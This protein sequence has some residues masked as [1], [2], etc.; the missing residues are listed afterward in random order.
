VTAE[1]DFP[2]AV[3]ERWEALGATWRVRTL[4]DVL[5]VVEL[6]TCHGTPVD[7][8]RSNDRELIRFLSAREIAPD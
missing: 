7:E 8:L 4:T 2:L 3:L 5:A 6:R 1:P